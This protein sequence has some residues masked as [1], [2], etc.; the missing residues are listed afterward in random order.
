[1]HLL[2]NKHND[3]HDDEFFVEIFT[4]QRGAFLFVLT[5]LVST[6]RFIV[7]L[8]KLEHLKALKQ[9]TALSLSSLLNSGLL[10]ICRLA[11]TFEYLGLYK[12]NAINFFP[13]F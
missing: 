1:M 13:F 6:I 12:K 4:E 5:C 9:M 2:R 7:A 8:E 10:L 3:D 11:I